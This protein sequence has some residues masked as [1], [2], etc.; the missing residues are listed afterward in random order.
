LDSRFS[1]ASNAESHE[2]LAASIT[3]NP[4]VD[5]VKMTE[6]KNVFV[7]IGSASKNSANQKLVDRFANLSKDDFNLTIFN[8]LKTLPHFDPEL[9]TDSPPN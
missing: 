9:S 5:R 7:I 1:N 3:S 2:P 6:K 8:D 4:R